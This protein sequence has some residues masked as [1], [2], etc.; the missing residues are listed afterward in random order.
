MCVFNQQILKQIA[1]IP[2]RE[3]SNL[4]RVFHIVKLCYSAIEYCTL[5]ILAILLR[6]QPHSHG[7]FHINL[8][9]ITVIQILIQWFAHVISIHWNNEV[10]MCNGFS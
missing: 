9:I 7:P 1:N 3:K 6:P 5:A 10:C 4:K 8:K 2:F